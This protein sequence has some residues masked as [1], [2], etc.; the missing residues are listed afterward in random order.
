MIDKW[1]HY[2][3]NRALYRKPP[4]KKGV[5]MKIRDVKKELKE[6]GFYEKKRKSKKSPHQIWEGIV[7]G[8]RKCIPISPSKYMRNGNI[9]VLIWMIRN[10][11][12]DNN[13]MREKNIRK[14]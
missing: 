4:N 11:I 5:W 7:D 3:Y 6:L 9:K 10:Q 8:K 2:H 12:N 1:K 13:F 14:D